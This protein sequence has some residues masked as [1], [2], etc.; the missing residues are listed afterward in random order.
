[1]ILTICAGALR[2]YLLEKNELPDKPLVAMIPVST[3]TDDEKNAMGNQVSAMF[4]QLATDVEDPVKRLEKIQLNTM[5]GKLYQEAIDARSLVGYAELVPFG[6]ASAAARLYN[7][8]SV[9]KH[10]R[11]FFNVTI[12]NVPGPQIPIYMAGHKFLANLGNAPI[13]DGMGLILPISSYNGTLSISSTSASNLIPDLD[14]FTRYI[15]ESANE[16]E[17]AVLVKLKNHTALQTLQK[18]G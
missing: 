6:L 5:V 16:L 3:R 14:V 13:V 9:A 10:H 18:N 15:R 17:E 8:A 11:P 7:R 1:M 2:R 4:I 12:T